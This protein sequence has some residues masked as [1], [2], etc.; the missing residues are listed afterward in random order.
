VWNKILVDDKGTGV[1][2]FYPFIVNDLTA[3]DVVKQIDPS[4]SELN[5]LAPEF[6]I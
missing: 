5:L 1:K 2:K 4:L 3:L 6:Y